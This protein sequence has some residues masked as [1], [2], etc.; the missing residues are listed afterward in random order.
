MLF[1]EIDVRLERLDFN[2]EALV[3]MAVACGPA[4]DVPAAE[5]VPAVR[6]LRMNAVWPSGR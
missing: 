3:V 6:T 5:L 1:P 4:R 2:A